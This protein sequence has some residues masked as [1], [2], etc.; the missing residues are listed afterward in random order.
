M[1]MLS[2]LVL[3]YF[4][5]DVLSVVLVDNLVMLWYV[6]GYFLF[7]NVKAMEF[8]GVIVEIFDFLGGEVVWDFCG[9]VIGVFEEWAMSFIN[10]VYDDYWAGFFEEVK[11]EEWYRAIELVEEEC[12]KKGVILF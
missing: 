5:Y 9:K 11:I 4:Y 12:L 10:V 3:G 7:V 1:E 2:L 8:V 6:S